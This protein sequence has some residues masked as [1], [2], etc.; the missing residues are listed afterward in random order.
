M[1]T[2]LVKLKEFVPVVVAIV[3][4]W[5]PK[6]KTYLLAKKMGKFNEGTLIRLYAE[7]SF[8]IGNSLDNNLVWKFLKHFVLLFLLGIVQF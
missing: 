3:M 4:I 7:D 1:K 6:Y 5:A 2:K 8:I